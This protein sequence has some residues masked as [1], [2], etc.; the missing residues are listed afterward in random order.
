MRS[1]KQQQQQIKQK[2]IP[3]RAPVGF[4][5]VSKLES[6]NADLP[7][8][9]RKSSSLYTFPLIVTEPGVATG[10]GL[11]AGLDVTVVPVADRVVLSFGFPA[12]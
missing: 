11:D 4:P 7:G 1:N 9:I 6:T 12:F 10:P 3:P 5:G 2:T 8:L